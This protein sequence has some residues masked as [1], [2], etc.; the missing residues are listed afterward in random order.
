MKN[1]MLMIGFV[2]SFQTA[3]AESMI[4]T[5]ERWGGEGAAVTVYSNRSAHL[6]FDCAAGYVDAS[7]W[8]YSNK[9]VQVKGSYVKHTGF[10]PPA[11]VTPKPSPAN[12]KA[13]VNA[14]NGSMQLTVTVSGSTR[15]YKLKKNAPSGIRRCM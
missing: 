9:V 13:I 8:I 1:L 11:G 5:S 15:T 2:L 10:R 4:S 12:F 14:R 7:G 6:D 3:Q